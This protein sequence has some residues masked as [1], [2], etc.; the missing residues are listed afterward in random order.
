MNK[1]FESAYERACDQ[2]HIIRV[3]LEAVKAAELHI[4]DEIAN[5]G[6]R[7][8]YADTELLSKLQDAINLAENR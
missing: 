1:V 4:H 2:Q 6:A 7:S 8:D 5:F 3:L